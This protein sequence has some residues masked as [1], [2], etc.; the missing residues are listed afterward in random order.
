MR[1]CRF[2]CDDLVLTGFLDDDVVIP[3]DQAAE[4]YSRETETEMLLSA[5][6]DLL[7]LLPP[8]G[9]S[10]EQAKRL[11]D[12][13]EELDVITVSELTI[14]LEEVRVLVPLPSPRKMLFLAGNYGKH[15]AE[16]GYRDTEREETFPYVFMKPPSTT[17]THPGD[18]IVIPAGS[19]DQIDWECELGVVIGRTC[20]DVSESTALEHVA[21]YTVVNDVSD[22][23]FRPNPGRKPRERDKFFDW[24]HGKWHD[25]FC[26][27]GPCILSAEAVPDP[28]A[29][30]IKLTVNGQIKQDATTAEMIFPVAAVVSFVSRFV[31]LEPGDVIATGTPSGVGSATG[32]FLRP[33]DV[34]RATIA[35]IGTLENPVRAETEDEFRAPFL[36]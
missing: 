28:Q 15:L 21:G 33:G 22:R 20:R 11:Y 6:E 31:T 13:I 19:P 2:L 27:M 3:I 14:P 25:T 1:V 34:V 12:W 18:P 36:G 24:L 8:D 29:L 32:V 9:Q 4:M 30:P 23:A 35:P 17:L 7:D 26:P 16:R 10:Y 5:T